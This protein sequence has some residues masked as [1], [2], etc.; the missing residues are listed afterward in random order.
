M[1]NKITEKYF[2]NASF[3]KQKQAIINEIIKKTNFQPIKE[4]FCGK[5]YDDNKIGSLIYK[6]NW[7][8]KT[9][10]LKIQGLQPEIDEIDIINNFNSQNKSKKIR[11]PILYNGSKWNKKDNY[12]YLLLEYINKP[13]IYKSPFANQSQIKDFCNF[14]QEYKTNCLKVPFITKSLCEQNSLSFTT[15]RIFL[16]K[17]IAQNKK[18]LTKTKENYVEKFISLAE[19]HLPL[20]EMNFM[21]GHLTSDDIFKFSDKKYIIMSNLFWSYRPEFYD[22][23]FHLWSGIK[24]LRNQNINIDQVIKYINHWLKEYKKYSVFTEDNDFEKKFNIM[25]IERCIGALLVDIENQY[26]DKDSKN[27][28]NHLTQ[29]FKNLFKH[30]ADKLKTI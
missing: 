21:H 5:I 9:T 19:K 25:M 24:S 30:F 12:G 14:Y 17:K 11:L 18:Y 22:S 26:Y 20:I 10:V 8:G 23:T 16:W 7:Q 4:I 27:N 28:I 2:K 15:E 6:G 1:G 13:T 29:L 3:I